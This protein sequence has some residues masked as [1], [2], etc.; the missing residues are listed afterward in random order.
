M[1]TDDL[2]LTGATMPPDGNNRDREPVNRAVAR[3][4][5]S[6]RLPPIGPSTV[7][8]L[9]LGSS[10]QTRQSRSHGARDSYAAV[11]V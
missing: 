8:A 1:S 5:V 9:P 10:E 6:E 2:E 7:R 4:R 3:D 11:R